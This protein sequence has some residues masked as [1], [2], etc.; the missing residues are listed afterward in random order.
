MCDEKGEFKVGNAS[1]IE[2]PVEVTAYCDAALVEHF[3]V[4]VVVTLYVS[5]EERNI[6]PA[7]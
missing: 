3:S 7:L 6:L 1:L 4:T 5:I 2:H